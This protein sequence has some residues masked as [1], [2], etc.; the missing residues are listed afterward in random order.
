MRSGAFRSVTCS[1]LLTPAVLAQVTVPV[2]LDDSGLLGTVG[3]NI[4]ILK[5]DSPGEAAIAVFAF[6][7]ALGNSGLF[8]VRINNALPVIEPPFPIPGTPGLAVDSLIATNGAGLV[9]YR[10]AIQ[11]QPEHSIVIAGPVRGPQNTGVVTIHPLP[12]FTEV[13]DPAISS[14][15]VVY[16]GARPGNDQNA[17]LYRIGPGS[18]IVQ[19][20][21][22][23]WNIPADVVSVVADSS[24][25]Q[26][27]NSSACT[28][29]TLLRGTG[30]GIPVEARFIWAFD[31]YTDIAPVLAGFFLPFSVSM[32]SVNGTVS[33]V[34]NDAIG[35]GII[36]DV[37]DQ[38]QELEPRRVT[39]GV[40]AAGSLN[41]AEN[42]CGTRVV[43][44]ARPDNTVPTYGPY[45][46][47]EGVRGLIV[48]SCAEGPA[49]FSR[50]QIG[51]EFFG[52]TI[53]SLETNP[54]AINNRGD[55]VFSATF[56]DGSSGLFAFP[57]IRTNCPGDADCDHTVT[58]RDITAILA[59][60]GTVFLPESFC[61][62]LGDSDFDK[63]V[64]FSDIT[65]TLSSLGNDCR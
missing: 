37:V 12:F 38:Y 21:G 29:S 3:S 46:P 59:N 63:S 5:L 44:T 64:S 60:L 26:F 32:E 13:T 15:G 54:R 65:A 57:S 48:Q 39:F 45:G 33:L 20:L 49:F 40:D 43:W 18:G 6:P 41:R 50:V 42:F 9:A 52:R 53:T 31:E 1:L 14:E 58:F 16:F 35:G 10:S 56:D 23:P 28:V 47:H 8:G 36:Q 11:F 62:P 30:L 55:F 24:C 34:Q 4:A 22:T 61:Y 7:S 25:R 51:A 19:D 17:R 27:A 2:A